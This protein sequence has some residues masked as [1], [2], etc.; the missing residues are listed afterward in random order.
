[1][2]AFDDYAPGADLPL[3]EYSIL[4][5]TFGLGVG[6]LIEADRRGLIALP[7][8]PEVRDLVL[9]GLSTHKL[10]RILARAKVTAPLR[11]PFTQLRGGSGAGEVDEQPRRGGWRNA[12][13]GLLGCNFCLGPWVATGLLAGLAIRP[14]AARAVMSVFSAVAAADFLHRG[15]VLCDPEREG[16]R[17]ERAAPAAEPATALVSHVH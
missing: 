10:T 5:A 3:R 13:G 12:L 17:R 1:M 4:V 2:D 6:A 14:R 8:R 7:E 15:W 16:A 9:L 11:A